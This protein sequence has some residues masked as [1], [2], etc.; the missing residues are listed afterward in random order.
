MHCLPSVGVC[1]WVRMAMPAYGLQARS[2]VS[3]LP[4]RNFYATMGGLEVA[5]GRTGQQ[6]EERSCEHMQEGM[7]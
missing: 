3:L 7:L 2:T 5:Q 1:A 6:G 4:L